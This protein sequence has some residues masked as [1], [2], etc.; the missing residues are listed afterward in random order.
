MDAHQ[1]IS[2]LRNP[3]GKSPDEMRDVRLAAADEI[4]KWRDAYENMR[5]WAVK[6]GVDVNTYGMH[7]R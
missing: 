2:F 6:C 4:E 3:Y 7:E 5:D 1:I